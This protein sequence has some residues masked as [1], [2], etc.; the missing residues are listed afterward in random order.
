VL[1]WGRKSRPLRARAVRAC[2]GCRALK[3][4]CPVAYA[5]LIVR[6]YP[7]HGDESWIHRGAKVSFCNKEFRELS[8][9]CHNI[10]R[11]KAGGPVGSGPRPSALGFGIVVKLDASAHI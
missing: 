1:P 8:S 7:Y 5:A 6:E 3:Q 9:F 11:H 2:G 4:D 10:D